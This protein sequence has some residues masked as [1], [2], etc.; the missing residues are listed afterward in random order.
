MEYELLSKVFYKDE[1]KYKELLEERKKQQIKLPL[2]IKGEA[3]FFLFNQEVGNCI[4]KIYK[5]MARVDS[6][7]RELPPAAL[8]QYVK[9]MLIEEI[10]L[11]NEIEGVISTRKE[12]EEA[13]NS[14]TKKVRLKGMVEKYQSII[15]E[16]G[17]LKINSAQDIRIIYDQFLKGEIDK[18]NLPDGDIFRKETVQVTTAT[19]KV[20]HHGL[21]GED[22][23]VKVLQEVLDFVNDD[24]SKVQLIIKIAF[25]HYAFG[26]IHPFYDGNGRLS[27]LIS[28]ALLK[29]EIG[30]LPALKLSSVV[31][32]NSKRYY[33]IF[34]WGNDVKN[35]G[36]LTPFII[37][38]L[39]FIMDAC[40][41]VEEELNDIDQRLKRY[42][43]IIKSLK[44]VDSEARL[45]YLLVQVALYSQSGISIKE[46][47]EITDWGESKT[48]ARLKE[49]DK[50][51]L[52]KIEKQGK[53]QVYIGNLEK[54]DEM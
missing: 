34:T 9:R 30:I 17:S 41:K 28:T 21:F 13:I 16:K 27:R 23:I 25:F 50:S 14:T 37:I 52:I 45:I 38:F 31:K 20:I 5:G 49:L 6:L 3:S 47:S 42:E 44:L 32:E 54:L 43:K 8:K 46:I 19:Q 12:V 26:Y 33:E 1:Q 48:R 18:R 35:K 24:T 15:Q 4:A 10:G 29:E 22:K 51:G 40:N 7:W 39:T 2:E 53:K 11:T 36:D